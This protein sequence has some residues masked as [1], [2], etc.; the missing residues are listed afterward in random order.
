[1]W[2][3][4]ACTIISA[5]SQKYGNLVES[6]TQFSIENFSQTTRSRLSIHKIPVSKRWKLC[7]IFI[8]DKIVYC[9]YQTQCELDWMSA[10]ALALL[11][12]WLLALS[13]FSFAYFVVLVDILVRFLI[14]GKFNYALLNVLCASST[15]HA[16]KY[17]NS[18]HG[19]K[20]EP[21]KMFLPNEMR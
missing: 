6:V 19:E 12:G 16:S 20:R 4:V 13:L 18:Y 3:H 8:G 17:F 15:V 5:N 9:H 21:F 14:H 1:M 11:F 2:V 10:R 7:K